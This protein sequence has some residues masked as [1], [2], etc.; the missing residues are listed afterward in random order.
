MA[1]VR[2]GV[3][4]YVA[5]ALALL[6]LSTATIATTAQSVPEILDILY[7]A[8][9]GDSWRNNDGWADDNTYNY[10]NWSGITCYTVNR[11]HELYN[12]I[13][14]LDLSSNRLV[15]AL[16]KDVFHIPFL[17][18][19]ILRDNPDLTVRFDDMQHAT[20]LNKLVL[21][22]TM[23]ESFDNLIGP[24]LREFHITGC[25]LNMP[26]PMEITNLKNL[27]A[28]YAN[29]NYFVGSLPEE[30]G[31]MVNLVELFLLQNDFGGTIPAS[32]GNLVNL[33]I[34][35]LSNNQ[36]TGP[37]PS[38]ALNNLVNLK[39][40][41][42]ADNLLE[43]SI[44]SL[45]GLRSI[46]E[47]YLGNNYFTGQIP[48][49]FLS[50]APKDQ[51]M[52]IDLSDNNLSGTFGA[53]R[54][55]DFYSI[56]LDLTGNEFTAIDSNLCQKMEWMG[57]AVGDYGCDAI[58]CPVGSW[59]PEGRRTAGFSCVS[60]CLSATFMGANN[61]DGD[62]KRILKEFYLALHGDYWEANNWFVSENECEWT[63]ITCN[64]NSEKNII[65]INLSGMKLS[66]TVPSSIFNF[67]ALETIDL[68]N[69]F[70]TF[71]FDGIRK[72][73]N[74]GVLDLSTTG[75]DSVED[76]E[77]LRDT[78]ISELDLSSNNINSAI[79]SAIY[80]L[81]NL[82]VLK[83]SYNK[84]SGTLSSDI[85]LLTNLEELFLFGNNLT[86]QI[87][88][89]IG[90]LGNTLKVA[91]LSENDF[92][93]EIPYSMSFMPVMENLSIHQKTNTRGGL[94]GNVP[95]FSGSPKLAYLN[96]SGNSLSGF[97]PSNF[98]VN[99]ERLGEDIFVDL[100]SNKIQGQI[101][102]S[103]D[104]FGYLNINLSNNMINHIHSSLCSMKGWQN[105]AL[106]ALD[107]CDPI[108]CAAGS[109]NANG[110]ATPGNECVPCPSAQFFGTTKCHE[111]GSDEV[112]WI[113][114]TFYAS[115]NGEEWSGGNGWLQSPDPCDGT[116]R[117]ITCDKDKVNILE[118]NLS[119]SGLTGTP[120]N[121]IFNLPRLQVLDLSY[122]DINFSFDGIGA[123]KDLRILKLSE[124]RVNSIAGVGQAISL[125]ELHLTGANLSGQI[126]DEVFNLVNLR[127]LYLN[128][129]RFTGRLSSKIGQLVNLENLFLL[130]NDL[131]GQIPA[132]IGDLKQMRALTL[133]QNHF[134]GSI[135]ESINQMQNL[136]VLAIQGTSVNSQSK[137]RRKLLGQS[138][139][140]Q[141][142]TGLTGTLPSFDGLKN[143][144]S[145][146]L[147]F[148]SLSG[149]IPYDFLSG[150]TDK[151][152]A[153]TIELDGNYLAGT[154]PASLTQF[155]NL[156]LS[157]GNNRFSSI[158]P[159]L[160]RMTNWLEGGI[161]NF[162][163]EG[164]LCPQ[165]TFS[166]NG[167]RTKDH[168]CEPC[169][170]NTV[171]P[172]VGSVR[173]ITVEEQEAEN[174][175]SILKLLYDSLDGVG[176]HSKSNWY[177]DTVPFC[178]WHGIT[179]TSSGSSIE[180]IHLGSNGLRGTLPDAVFD[181]PN[182]LELNLASNEV[183]I[184]FQSIG[185]ARKLEY[186]NIDENGIASLS[187]IKNVSTLRFLHASNNAFSTFPQEIL[188]LS[189]LQ[190]L[191]LSFNNFDTAFPNLSGLS[192]LSFFAC[193]RCGFHGALPTWLGSLSKLQYLSVSGNKLTGAIPDALTRISSLTH[194]D[195]SDQAPRGGGITGS[196]PSF[197]TLP[198]L[199]ELYL[200]KNKITGPISNDFLGNSTASS[201]TV[202]LR[203][204]FISGSVPPSLLS[205]FNDFTLLLAGNHIEEISDTICNTPPDNWNQ[206]DLTQFGC[207][208]LLCKQG[209][210]SPV[211]RETYGYNCEACAASD[212]NTVQK[213]LG[214][215]KC[216]TNTVV[217]SLESFYYTLSGPD[218]TNN[219]GWT[220]NDAYCTWYGIDCDSNGLIIGIDLAGNNL[221]GKVPKAIYEI[222]SLTYITLRENSITM[223]FN[224]IEKLTSLEKL[225]LS[226][227]GMTSIAGIGAALPLKELH[228][229]SNKLTSI[230]DELFNLLNLEFLYMNF[231][232]IQGN[233]SSKIG[234]FKSLRELY[235][236]RNKLSG[237]LPKEISLL[238][239]IRVLDL[240]ENNF[241]G[242][243]PSGISD[244]QFV[245]I[246]ALQH[247]SANGAVAGAPILD[248][249]ELGLS[250]KLPAFDNNPKLKELYL[251]FNNLSGVIPNSFLRA[252]ESKTDEIVI[253]LAGNA[254]TGALP[255]ILNQF[256]NM[257][258][259]LAGNQISQM[260]ES[261]CANVGWMN[262]RVEKSGCDA[263]LCPVGYY[264]DFG[265]QATDENPCEPCPFTFTAD[266]YGSTSCTPDST[267]Y[268][269]QEIL[270][271]LYH[272]TD[273]SRWLDADNWLNNKVSI[274]DWHGVF[275]E[276]Q[277]SVGEMVVTEIHLPSNKLKGTIPPQVF[278]L[279]NLRMLNLRDNKV[280]VQL[281]AMRESPTLQEL[282][283][284]YTNLSS[285][286]GIG[287]A[288]NL[289]TLHV[290]QNNLR[291]STIP[292]ELYSLTGLKH[293]Y[294]S[295]ANLSGPL[296]SKIGN[297][298]QLQDFYCHGNDLSGE[299][300][301]SIG[302]LTDLE[303]L[304]LSENLFVGPI[305]DSIVRLTKL[306]SLFID[307]F[308][309]RSAGLS[310][311]L[312]SFEGMPALR[313]LYLNSN[314][315]TGQIP[316]S[317]LSNEKLILE[318]N[319]SPQSLVA[320]ARRKQR[321]NVGLKGNRLEGSI[322]ASL[323][324]FQR[325]NIDVSDNL[326]TAIDDELCFVGPW[327]GGDVANYGCNAILCPAGS[328]NLYGRQTNVRS[329]CKV[330]EG[331]E[332]SQFLGATK[333]LSEVK[334]KER[335][336][337]EL[338]YERCGGDNWKN[339]EGWLQEST[340]I[341]NWYG[342]SCS[343]GGSVET[344]D[345]GAN[346]II[347]TPPSEIFDLENLKYLWLYSNP[348]KFSFEGIGRARRLE[349]LLLDSTGLESLNGV[350]KAYQ[351]VDLDVRFNNLRGQIPDELSN[352]VNLENLSLSD[353]KF[354][355]SLPSLSRM[356]RLKS[357]RASNNRF[358]GLLP[359][360]E[361]NYKL[362][363]I[364][365]SGNKISGNIP[366]SFLESVS[367]E[368]DI[369]I[370]LSKN[371]IEGSVPGELSR[372]EKMTIYLKDNYL[373]GVGGEICDNISWNEGDVG[374]YSC[375]AI[376][377]PA[378][379]Y[380]PGTGRQ[381]LGGTKC[382]DCKIAKFYGQSQC[383]DLQDVY[384][385][386]FSSSI[387]IMV[388]FLV[389]GV[390]YLLI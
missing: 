137:S 229:T 218:W 355:G 303:V 370:D 380:A 5:K 31:T 356:H 381:S 238:E 379:T 120:D 327:M 28:L 298:K 342:I 361:E 197:T 388:T 241:S 53:A 190:V 132:S 352:L 266:Y 96:L 220:E 289:K 319:L 358:T 332:Q 188:S 201:V 139:R 195:L 247:V 74:L 111:L 339:N 212:D 46:R 334:K 325:L 93:G 144:D 4:I 276:N 19:L 118:I 92:T 145:L 86:G 38:D 83:L 142:V 115:T 284:D 333:C 296:S 87:P 205:R 372:F 43:N 154:V 264:N 236:F 67:D 258:V 232:Q 222:T 56:D 189:N 97:L 140:T 359:S 369:Y 228:F 219:Q 320:L 204:N 110:R 233:L 62:K 90:V 119:E 373:F 158:A 181:L 346:N 286:E 209:F 386:A 336:I 301:E 275:C 107:G 268:N 6:L 138:R 328:Y 44:P 16:P 324:K 235:M 231:N 63:G 50:S 125:N 103:W 185:N 122:N 387:G 101:P 297:L 128:Y 270:T 271:K 214:S 200:Q 80:R 251:A 126:P 203:R 331:A 170:E 156:N 3:G 261:I 167:R 187:G 73:T 23:I 20:M 61:C 256:T 94:T 278:N 223:D 389:T 309:R 280:D 72:L 290:Q 26:F 215:T 40:L 323:A 263:I 182:L 390:T 8:T 55:K 226:M 345:L 343:N 191:Y 239:N 173:C 288:K 9:S 162:D 32:I 34:L 242:D 168:I 75:L 304:V 29:Y 174:E 88:D 260:N 76:I 155:S 227:T 277:A 351:L 300:P 329:P 179:C 273:G 133:S 112:W 148:N 237:P 166:Q 136:E 314:S 69:N 57:G 177:D 164:L 354:T 184:N 243:I 99:S 366:K 35:V 350:G 340:D 10:C 58:L 245:E 54:L 165:N 95:H 66:G 287:K 27:E 42:L 347:G 213:F 11:Y 147:A 257:N 210:F 371:R 208:G 217:Q 283:L 234:Q 295:D 33:E 198:S 335:D 376:L 353:N 100:S 68:S 121:I 246:I 39:V 77:Q 330:C 362:K 306:E 2:T 161:E 1:S 89:E 24:E 149:K 240:G 272:A 85:G 48:M 337:L 385:N 317:F 70:I 338:F 299:L 186:L 41:S 64:N 262:G 267:D 196:L 279:R 178:D 81:N 249:S 91:I 206:G 308:T 160:C 383:V 13:E 326:I 78:S 60:G 104:M 124:T 135:P 322:P 375:D 131:T 318:N 153:I 285:L 254:I 79:P 171:A 82:R 193:K 18:N 349:S 269:E 313:Q 36:L 22:N 12:Q 348:I 51:V 157:L 7:S 255:L 357:F 108:L 321:I 146:Y 225:N 65:A 37:V 15:G 364:D 248:S 109:F 282:Y 368:E 52:I 127:G 252:V 102:S 130:R 344:I 253:D 151:S 221:V 159:G 224:G 45:D 114:E 17:S 21:S 302:D 199:S 116:W 117:G 175:R 30:I 315:L 141:L 384:S 152:K 176:W 293:L 163:C 47:L 382:I 216:G 305:P 378:G 291:G 49:N 194:L 192:Q 134:V 360:F 14:T 25:S 365:L 98:M 311:P 363:T 106:G 281:F 265:R 374:R 123:A 294:I 172:F 143:L 183:V 367:D 207:D 113:L 307:S 169:P 244:L 150:I 292:D 310:G 105:G 230:P 259:Y 250:G 71:K 316:E 59:A 202:D 377:C 129:N 180:A 312:P 274:C 84:F 211:G 341:C